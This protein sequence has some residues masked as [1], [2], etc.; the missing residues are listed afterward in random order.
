[1]IE[2]FLPWAGTILACI[3]LVLTTFWGLYHLDRATDLDLEN[4]EYQEQIKEL[5][6]END[7][8]DNEKT[9]MYGQLIEQDRRIEDDNN[10][11]SNL[12]KALHD[13]V[14]ECLNIQEK[15]TALYNKH[16]KVGVPLPERDSIGRF[17]KSSKF[18]E[19]TAK[20]REEVANGQSYKLS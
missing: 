17:V 3:L 4:Q 11:I 12:T 20:L 19:T 10:R 6:K 14:K 16:H 1:M 9:D 7:A 5:K 15:Y 18:K 13:K 2:T 8:C